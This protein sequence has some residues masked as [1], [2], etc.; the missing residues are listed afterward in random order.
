VSGWLLAV[1]L[2]RAG[3]QDDY[4]AGLAALR[5]GDHAAAVERLAA[6]QAAGGEDPA[7]YH[8]LGNALYRQ[9]RL[10]EAMAAWRRGLVLEP[11][12]ADL[13]VNLERARSE[14][15]D[16]LAPPVVELGPFFWQRWLSRRASAMLAS[17]A[18]TAG[19][20]MLVSVRL[21]WAAAGALLVSGLLVAST[22]QAGRAA[23]NATVIAEEVSAQSAPS[24]SG[25]ALFVLHEG[26]EVR[27]LEQPAGGAVL[28]VLSDG[29]K[30]WLPAGALRST[31]PGDPFPVQIQDSSSASEK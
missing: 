13:V 5:A 6:A 23:Q 16:K 22:W 9:D 25:V 21:R 28:V 17:A 3:V 26:A 4:E 7:V 19:L 30:G 27:V 12:S 15:R 31:M 2:A 11:G 10:G 1:A 18:A 29:R 24:D 8:A 20:V 14:T